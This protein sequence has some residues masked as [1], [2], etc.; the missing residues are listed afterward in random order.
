MRDLTSVLASHRV[1]VCVGSGGVGKTTTAASLALWGALQGRRTAVVTIDPAKRLADCLGLQLSAVGANHITPE[2]FARYGLR[3]AGSLTALLVDQQSAWDAA[4]EKYAPTPEIR[5]R[6]FANRF[7]HGLSRGFAG[8]HEYMALDTL[9]TLSLSDDYDLI[10]LDTPPVQQALDFLDAPLRLQRFL[11]SRVS[12]WLMRPA[13]ER[14][15]S[16]LSFANRTTSM[17]LRKVEDATGISA[18]GEIAEFFSSLHGMLEDFT[19][20]SLR[21]SALLASHET[22][23]VLVASPDEAVLREAEQFGATLERMQ[24]LLK[25][26]VL[27]RVHV[28][29]HEET[30]P[31]DAKRLTKRLQPLF[32]SSLG[33]THL[34]WLA[35]NFL[36]HQ[37]LAHSEAERISQLTSKTPSATPIVQ[38][39]ILQTTLVDLRGL[40]ALHPYLCAATSGSQ[41][42][43]EP[44]P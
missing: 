42:N 22:A 35:D 12:Q 30:H 34:Q 20:R 18:L 14:S 16:A 9:A 6:L 33:K 13:V 24:I 19:A 21:V 43:A 32:A 27:N 2:T 5:D 17:L 39:P 29:H 28:L 44:R 40:T 37:E 23:F 11:D 36:A 1:I 41:T 4:I 7:Y 15:W 10:V 38:V 8:S 3:P 31:Q 25:G 26:I